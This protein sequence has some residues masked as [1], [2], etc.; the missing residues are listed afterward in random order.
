MLIY[1]NRARKNFG[2]GV[3]EMMHKIKE[4]KPSEEKQDTI[5]EVIVP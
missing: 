4:K 1:S 5:E 2:Q 3:N